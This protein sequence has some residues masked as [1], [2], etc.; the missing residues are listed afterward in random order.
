[1]ARKDEIQARLKEAMLSKDE[2]ARDTLRMLKSEWGAEEARL[3]RD[4]DEG[5]ELKLLKR[6]VK[7]RKDSIASYR[8][9]GRED[10]AAREEQEIAVIQEF[11][12]Q[13]MG[14]AALLEAMTSLVHEL[15]LEG[16]KDMGRLM[17]E[18]MARYPGQV[19]GKVASGVAGRLLA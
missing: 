7:S 12:P 11:L 14:E 5:E 15:G 8:E 17:K 10:A 16:K 18:V 4:L 19:D 9:A 13:S 2:V 6:A 1:M 3:G